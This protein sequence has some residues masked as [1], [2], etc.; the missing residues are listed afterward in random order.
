MSPSS[1]TSPTAAAPLRGPPARRTATSA[2]TRRLA[3][4]GKDHQPAH[5]HRVPAHR[6]RRPLPRRL[7]RDLCRR[8]GRD[9]HRRPTSALSPGSQNAA[10][11]SNGCSPTTAAATAPTPG[12]TPAQ[13]R[14]HPQTHPALPTPDQR[15][16]RAVPPHPGRR[17]GLRPFLRLRRPT[18]SR[19]PGWIH[20]YNHHRIHSA[21]GGT[22]ISRLNN[23]PGHHT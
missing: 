10:S 20:F 13:P 15:Q 21:I 2:A 23:L 9:R 6:D 5:R 4:K 16:D 18:P 1:A 19:P 3:R 17:L 22:P 12:V 14:H 8:E 11:P 7:R